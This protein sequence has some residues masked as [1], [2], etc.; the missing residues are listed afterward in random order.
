VQMLRSIVPGDLPVCLEGPL[1][2]RMSPSLMRA[3]SS[4]VKV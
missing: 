3:R 2:T 4:L 1:I